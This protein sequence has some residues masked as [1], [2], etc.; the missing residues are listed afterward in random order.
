MTDDQ[1]KITCLQI[2]DQVALELPVK[3]CIVVTWAPGGL[4]YAF[5]SFSRLHFLQIMK[6]KEMK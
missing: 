4:A 3:F 5:R 6:S 1:W 2:H